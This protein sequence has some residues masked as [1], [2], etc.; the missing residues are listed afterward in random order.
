MKIDE[1]IVCKIISQILREVAGCDWVELSLK[2]P[3]LSNQLGGI[4]ASK[5]LS[6][7]EKVDLPIGWKAFDLI[8]PCLYLR[9]LVFNEVGKRVWGL[10]FVLY[11]DNS[12]MME[13]NYNQ[14]EDYEDEMYFDFSKEVER[15]FI[16][17]NITLENSS[18]LDTVC[19]KYSIYREQLELKNKTIFNA[20][21]NKMIQECDIDL[22]MGVINFKVGDGW[23]TFEMNVIGILNIPLEKFTWSWE[24]ALIPE[25]LQEVALLVKD[26]GKDKNIKDLQDFISPCH[27]DYAWDLTSLA[28]HLSDADGAHRVRMDDNWVYVVFLKEN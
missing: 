3:V 15:D 10:E 28:V 9:K 14:P 2:C 26:Y 20:F 17:S 12:Y 21:K 11:S 1:N 22:V 18:Q 5:T 13:Y 23:E 27:E 19:D 4:E 7:K 6:N 25:D 24:I 8:E 16:L